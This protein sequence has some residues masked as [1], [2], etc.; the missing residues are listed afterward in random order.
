MLK[1]YYVE[2]WEIKFLA[3]G[4]FHTMSTYYLEYRRDDNI[5]VVDKNL[6]VFNLR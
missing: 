1:Y 5:L 3:D 2:W 6:K 4:D